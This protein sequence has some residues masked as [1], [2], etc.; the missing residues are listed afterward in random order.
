[1]FSVF[2]FKTGNLNSSKYKNYMISEHINKKLKGIMKQIID[3]LLYH[4]DVAVVL[5]NS[6]LIEEVFMKQSFLFQR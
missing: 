6:D 4:V 3:L 1:M 5:L 2:H